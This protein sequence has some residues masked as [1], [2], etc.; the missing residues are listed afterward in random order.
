M[1]SK[2]KWNEGTSDIIFRMCVA[3]TNVH[4]KQNRLRS[5]DNEW[6]NQCRNRLLQ[7]GE[8]KKRE[9]ASTQQKCS[10]KRRTRLSLQFRD[11]DLETD[12]ET[13]ISITCRFPIKIRRDIL[14]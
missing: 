13:Q 5:E 1:S 10:F 3:L 7:I 8:D 4:V 9:R 12:D 11:G 14:Q 2:Y 6:Y